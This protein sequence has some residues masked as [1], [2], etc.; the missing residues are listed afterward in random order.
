MN[1]V[2]SST[3]AKSQKVNP[4]KSRSFTDISVPASASIT[5]KSPTTRLKYYLDCVASTL[6]LV[7]AKLTTQDELRDLIC[8]SN[9][10]L[11]DYQISKLLVLCALL[12]PRVLNNKCIFLPPAEYNVVSNQF[13]DLKTAKKDGLITNNQPFD[14]AIADEHIS[15]TVTGVMLCTDDWIYRNFVEPF[16]DLAGDEGWDWE[17]DIVKHSVKNKEKPATKSKT[18]VIL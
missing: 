14:I 2:S 1:A 12:E 17:E 8:K 18:C 13:L 3:M 9:G 10:D 6:D 15:V 11:T 5:S 16:A 7:Q 4:M